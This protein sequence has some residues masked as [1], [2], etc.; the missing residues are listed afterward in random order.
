MLLRHRGEDY[1]ESHPV[2]GRKFGIGYGASAT[3]GGAYT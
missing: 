3:F 2:G 1:A